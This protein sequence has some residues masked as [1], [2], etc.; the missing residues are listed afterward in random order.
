MAIPIVHSAFLNG[1]LASAG[2]SVCFWDF[3]E[4]KLS[5]QRA[6]RPHVSRSCRRVQHIFLKWLGDWPSLSP[7]LSLSLSLSVSLCMSL[8]LSVC[9]SGVYS[10]LPCGIC[11]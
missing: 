10:V 6:R 11:E 1:Q 3:C 4:W 5:S 2:F 7:P 8:P 9:L